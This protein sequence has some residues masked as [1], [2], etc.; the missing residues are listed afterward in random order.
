MTEGA[1]ARIG[2]IRRERLKSDGKW[3]LRVVRHP[4][5]SL[6]IHEVL[7][8]DDGTVSFWKVEGAEAV[9]EVGDLDELIKS[10]EFTYTSSLEAVAKP[11]LEMGD[12]PGGQ[13]PS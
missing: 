8:A 3:N 4:C 2:R 13:K 9:D 5:G 6:A 12:L 11:I 7:Y 10:V 1:K